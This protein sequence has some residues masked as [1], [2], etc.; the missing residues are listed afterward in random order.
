MATSLSGCTAHHTGTQVEFSST[1]PHEGTP[2]TEF[3]R[4][5]DASYVRKFFNKTLTFPDGL[6]TEIWSFED[7]IGS[8]RRF[9]APV[10]RA[11]EG[12]IVHVLLESSKRVHTIHHHGI[13]P[14]PRNDGVGHT[15]FEVTGHYTYQWQPEVGEPGNPNLGSAGSYFYHCHVNTVLHVQM[16]MFGP[17][18]FDPAGGRGK[19][20][21]DDPVGYDITCEAI[22]VP[23]A[24]D[25]RWHTL[26]HAAGLDGEDVGLN[27]FEPTNFYLMGG[28]LDTE[29]K[30]P[31]TTDPDVHI[32]DRILT[33]PPGDQPGLLRILD[34]Q[35]FPT[36]VRFGGGLKAELI[37]HDGRPF[38]DTSRRPSPP[39][40]VMTDKV[41]FGTAERYDMRLHP[42]AGAISGD[43]F[44][45]TVDFFNWI[46]EAVVGTATTVVEI[47]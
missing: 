5:P 40:S 46:G 22:M 12:E 27:R 20:F 1:Q 18:I 33:R 47:V 31:L 21:I 34:G 39:I 28:N 9:P 26:Q 15:S 38:R 45:V 4:T 43:T 23:Y 35:Y 13:E 7:D 32:C 41:A 3:E 30:V 37:A 11:V 29:G 16:G 14:D 17:M 42:P 36:Q 19:A 6:A 2:V 44:P 25:P 8:G 10:T 24:V